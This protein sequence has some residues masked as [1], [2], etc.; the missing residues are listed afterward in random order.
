[1]Q[2]KSQGILLLAIPYLGKGRILKVFTE[3]AGLITLVSKKP[4]LA[5]FS[6][7]CIAEWIYQKKQSEI[8][9]LL[10]GS[11]IDGLLSLRQSYATLTA[12][13]SMAQDLLRTQLPAK[14][15]PGLYHLLSSYFKKTFSF[16]CPAILAASFRMKLLL[17]EGLLALQTNCIHCDLPATSL[18]QGESVCP[19][20]SSPSAIGFSISEWQIL[21]CLTFAKQFSLLQQ[22]DCPP[23]LN[24]KLT[25]LFE[26]RT[27]Y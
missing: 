5:V 8:F 19:A 3:D 12:A 9:T 23:S 24:E 27:K 15:A 18:M 1:M 4:S 11:L 20:H 16:E 6:P 14:S 7:F 13:G 21:H 10:E 17:H 25:A 22:I 2:T 26:E